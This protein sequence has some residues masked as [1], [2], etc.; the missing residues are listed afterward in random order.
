MI[1]MVPHVCHLNLRRAI[2]HCW[3][4]HHF[5]CHHFPHPS[6]PYHFN[7][8]RLIIT[9]I[10]YY[11]YYYWLNNSWNYK[12]FFFFPNLFRLKN[13][14]VGINTGFPISPSTCFKI[15][16]INLIL[17]LKFF[18]LSRFVIITRVSPH[19]WSHFTMWNITHV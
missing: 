10:N 3:W 17:A 16:Y 18:S 9:I 11:Y 14:I 7:T 19:L 13:G 5:S 8:F 6:P 15:K 1:L 4:T 2:V 12:E